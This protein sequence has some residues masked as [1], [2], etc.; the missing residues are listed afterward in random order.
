[1][2]QDILTDLGEEYLIKNGFD[3]ATV[4]V[5]LYNDA[6]DNLGDTDDIAAITTEPT[7]T[8]YARQSSTVS[9]ADLSGDWGFENDSTLTF[10]F[11]DQTTSETVDTAAYIVNFQAVDTGDAGA[12]DHLV[13]TGALSQDRDIGSID[14]LEFAAGDLEL[15]VT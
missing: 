10:D 2:T 11:S 5:A 12:N 13:A 4:I 1:M 15:T 3:G 8:N 14:T 7:N 9:A 6:T